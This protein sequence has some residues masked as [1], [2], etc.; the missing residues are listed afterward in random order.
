MTTGAIQRTLTDWQLRWLGDS[1]TAFV[2]PWSAGD[3]QFISAPGKPLKLVHRGFVFDWDPITGRAIVDTTTT[4]V[5]RTLG[6]TACKLL[7]VR[8]LR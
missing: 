8:T 3:A 1:F 6:A 2:Q 5:T 7:S 4:R